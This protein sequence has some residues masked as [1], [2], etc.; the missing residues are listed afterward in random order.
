MS[1]CSFGAPIGREVDAVEEL[2]GIEVIDFA[3]SV[4]ISEDVSFS[5]PAGLEPVVDEDGDIL[6]FDDA[7][8][9]QV[10][11]EDAV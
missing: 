2:I 5:R 6:C 4:D 7:V 8:G 11:Q 9:V 1:I 3:V 10:V